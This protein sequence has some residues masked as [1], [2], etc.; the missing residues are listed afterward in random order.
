M[1]VNKDFHN[2]CFVLSFLGKGPI[3]ENIMSSDI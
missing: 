2:K 3:T 1:H